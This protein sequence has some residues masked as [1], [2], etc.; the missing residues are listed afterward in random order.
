VDVTRRPSIEIVWREV[1][2]L[3]N[4]H[5]VNICYLR[6]DD[7]LTTLAF[8]VGYAW[9]HGTSSRAEVQVLRDTAPAWASTGTDAPSERPRLRRVVREVLRAS[10]LMF[11]R[12]RF[13]VIANA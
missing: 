11:R 5:G 8:V 12:G 1:D 6:D 13:V 2:E 10:S 4:G 9:R 3:S 7:S